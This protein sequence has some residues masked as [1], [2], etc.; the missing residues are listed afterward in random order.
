MDYLIGHLVGDFLLQNS[1]MAYG[2][3]ERWLPLLSHTLIYTGCI[4]LATGW[5]PGALAVVAAAHLVLDGT[6][7]MRLYNAR[8]KGEAPAPWLDIATD[9]ALHLVVLFLLDRMQGSIYTDN[10]LLG[11]LLVIASIAA[12]CLYRLAAPRSPAH[13]WPASRNAHVRIHA[14]KRRQPIGG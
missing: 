10:T 11:L 13:S 9:Q 12:L 3:K 2:K 1:W 7:L 5:K 4:S 6:D 14:R 8:I